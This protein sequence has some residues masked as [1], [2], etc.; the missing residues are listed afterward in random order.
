MFDL[1]KFMIG[2]G[3][4][5]EPEQGESI[6]QPLPR[7][8]NIPKQEQNRMD[9]KTDSFQEHDNTKKRSPEIEK[10]VEASDWSD[11]EEASGDLAKD[12]LRIDQTNTENKCQV[13]ELEVSNWSDGADSFKLEKHAQTQSDKKEIVKDDPESPVWSDDDLQ[14][15][16]SN[17]NQDKSVS[18]ESD[19]H[20]K[21]I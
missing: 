2:T 12:W 16:S 3:S 13:E 1:S 18:L 5:G 17:K 10:D 8:K 20:S 4:D 15:W 6:P 21:H 19:K 14:S 7:S 9:G 11:G